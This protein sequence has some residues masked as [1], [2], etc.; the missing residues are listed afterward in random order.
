MDAPTYVVNVDVAVHD[1]DTYL[2]IERAASE[3][4]AAGQL[5]F[6]GGKLE[7]P[8]G[9]DGAIAATARREVREEVGLE[10]GPVEYVCSRTFRADD[11]T[12]CLNVVTR[13]PRAGGTATAREPDE[14]AAVHWLTPAEVRSREPPAYLLG[15]LEQVAASR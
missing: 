2:L 15:Y 13:A 14:V 3:D 4:H 1:D 7:A 8:P 9:T 11:G 5:A 10:L 12:R 6:P